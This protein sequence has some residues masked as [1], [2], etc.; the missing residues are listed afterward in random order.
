MNTEFGKI[1]DLTQKIGKEL[2]P[3]QKEMKIATR[4]VSVMALRIESLFFLAF[5]LGKVNRPIPSFLPSA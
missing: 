2:S 1:A 4:I 5:L 3:L